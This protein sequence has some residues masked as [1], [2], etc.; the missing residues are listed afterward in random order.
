MLGYRRKWGQIDCFVSFFFLLEKGS[1]KGA[2]TIKGEFNNS[3]QKRD[4]P[5]QRGGA[6]GW[7]TQ[8]ARLEKMVDAGYGVSVGKL[9]TGFC[10]QAERKK[11]TSHCMEP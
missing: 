2:K 11:F 7:H 4:T 10:P 5:S 9:Y 3:Q 6:N 8:C 1:E